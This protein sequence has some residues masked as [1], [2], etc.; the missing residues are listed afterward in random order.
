M[1]VFPIS[2]FKMMA[3]DVTVFY[4]TTAGKPCIRYDNCDILVLEND[5]AEI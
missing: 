4:R 5:N 3:N 2:F 1:N